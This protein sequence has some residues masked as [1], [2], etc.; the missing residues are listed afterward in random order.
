MQSVCKSTRAR[1]AKCP[2]MALASPQGPVAQ[3]S[4]QR[5]HN[6]SV[7]GSNPSR[8]IALLGGDFL[9]TPQ[10]RRTSVGNGLGNSPWL[11]SAPPTPNAYIDEAG[12]EGFTRLGWRR[13]GVEEA[14]SEWLIPVSPLCPQGTSGSGRTVNRHDHQQPDGDRARG[15]RSSRQDLPPGRQSGEPSATPTAPR[16]RGPRVRL[17]RHAT[18]C[19]GPLESV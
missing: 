5:T 19:T 16:L 6:P 14:S 18:R 10:T 12:D 7:D 3:R 4:E 17:C 13:R 9:A 8:P 11:H 15:Q 1:K 2:P